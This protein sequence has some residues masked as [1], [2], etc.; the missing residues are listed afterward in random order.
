MPLSWRRKISRLYSLEVATIHLLEAQD[1]ACL[2]A[3]EGAIRTL[4][5]KRTNL[6]LGKS[7]ILL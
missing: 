5:A 6:F 7:L 4:G 3:A 1:F 2:Q